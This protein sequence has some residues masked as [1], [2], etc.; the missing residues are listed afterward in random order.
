MPS[1]ITTLQI[2]KAGRINIPRHIRDALE[3]AGGDLVRVTLTK[4]VLGE[5]KQGDTET[6][7]PAA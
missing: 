5:D 7:L 6:S 3:L 4:E 1:I 2:D